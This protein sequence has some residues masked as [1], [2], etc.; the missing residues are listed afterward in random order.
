MRSDIAV[1]PVKAFRE[2]CEAD[3][4]LMGPDRGCEEYPPHAADKTEI[5]SSWAS[6]AV[7]ARPDV[8]WLLG[9]H[10]PVR[11]EDVLQAIARLDRVELHP[12]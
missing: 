7:E 6:D 10:A 4:G 9:S 1:H 12:L 8:R 2:A 5:R 11:I 3:G